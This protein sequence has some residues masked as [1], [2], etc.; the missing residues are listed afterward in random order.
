[1]TE[2]HLGHALKEIEI[3]HQERHKVISETVKEIHNLQLSDL[4]DKQRKVTDIREEYKKGKHSLR[5][6]VLTQTDKIESTIASCSNSFLD[7]IDHFYDVEEMR[8]SQACDEIEELRV[9][10]RKQCEDAENLLN[11]NDTRRFIGMENSNIVKIL[12]NVIQYQALS[13]IKRVSFIV[14]KKLDSRQIGT[15]IGTL[16]FPSFDFPDHKSESIQLKFIFEFDKIDKYEIISPLDLNNVWVRDK[17][18]GAVCMWRR[19]RT[20]K[21]LNTKRV[22]VN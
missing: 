8:L 1:M 20:I 13:N 2:N 10:L 12:Q 16:Q 18:T 14:Q 21:I 17:Q 11:S 5:A 15:L 6:K 4:S 9:L 7:K 22:M 19:V 3:V